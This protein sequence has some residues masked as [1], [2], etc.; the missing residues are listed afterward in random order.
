MAYIRAAVKY[1]Y[2]VG[3]I[4]QDQTQRMV[5]PV[6]KNERHAY[7]KRKEML[8][9]AWACTDRQAR[10]AI[11]IAFYSGMR[12][13]EVLRAKPRK[14]GYLLE[15]TKNGER[16][17][18]PIH[19]KIAVLARRV[20]FTISENK[21]GHE[22]SKA[23]R[24]AGLEHVRFHDLRHAAASEM[25]NSGVDLLTVGEVLGHKDL[26]STKRYS[27]L[28]SDRLADAVRKIGGKR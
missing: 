11:R 10:A 23:R 9:I 16:R 21:L 15:E 1:A 24:K 3:M 13:G 12:R 2:K 18:V 20:R 4:D 17:M 7:P 26:S 8:Q 5:M 14:N 25:V 6:V 19:P 22:F 27:H 28:L